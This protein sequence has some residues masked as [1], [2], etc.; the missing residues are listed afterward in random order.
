MIGVRKIFHV[1]VFSNRQIMKDPVPGVNCCI[2]CFFGRCSATSSSFSVIRIAAWSVL[3]LRQY[4][5]Q[6]LHVAYVR[7]SFWV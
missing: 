4:V 2:E 1:N 5:M 6:G 7:D 3:L